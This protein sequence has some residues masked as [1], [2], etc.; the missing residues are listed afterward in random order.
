MICADLWAVASWITETAVAPEP[1]HPQP[2]TSRSIVAPPRI[3]VAEFDRH[4][5][6]PGSGTASRGGA[7][8]FD[9]P[10]RS[11]GTGRRRRSGAAYLAGADHR[12]GGGCGGYPPG[13][14]DRYSFDDL[15]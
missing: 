2:W 5:I 11:V 3:V 9:L 13:R 8:R 15:H 6:L 7:V 14:A 1:V 4:P 12:P 10:C